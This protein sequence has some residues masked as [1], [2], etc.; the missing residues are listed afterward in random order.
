MGMYFCCSC[1]ST[2]GFN[3]L[4]GDAIRNT[5]IHNLKAL[6]LVNNHDSKHFSTK[7]C[8]PKTSF[9]FLHEVHNLLNQTG[10]CLQSNLNFCI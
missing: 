5:V 10:T 6:S 7:N 4:P 8:Q 1:T 3:C 9:T 2:K